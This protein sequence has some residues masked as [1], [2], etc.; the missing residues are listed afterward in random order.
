MDLQ[1]GIDSAAHLGAIEGIGT[2]IAVLGHGFNYKYPKCNEKLYD[3]IIENNGCIITEYKETIRPWLGNFPRR[4]RLIS[5]IS[6]GVLIIE[7]GI[8][9]GS[10]ITAK[11]AKNQKKKI[12]CIPSNLGSTKGEGTN[13]LISKGEAKLVTNVEEILSEYNIEKNLVS[14]IKPRE[15]NIN[16]VYL[17]VYDVISRNPISINEIC[18]KTKLDISRI[19]YI[20]TMLEIEELIQ[21]L[22]GKEFILK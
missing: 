1:N 11:F 19:N 17:P 22:P 4:D 14:E 16:K 20:L 9:S 6:M 12:F 8:K 18:K 21:E 2:T 10:M 13:L 7:A 3:K 15:L 5:G